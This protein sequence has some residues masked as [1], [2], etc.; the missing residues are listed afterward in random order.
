M[1]SGRG[2]QRLGGAANWSLPSPHPAAA[3]ASRSLPRRNLSLFM[4]GGRRSTSGTGAVVASGRPLSAA[5]EVF[6]GD[7]LDTFS[8]LRA[9]PV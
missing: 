4:L 7:A 5:A 8:S 2:R 1:G 6:G 3:Y 9:R